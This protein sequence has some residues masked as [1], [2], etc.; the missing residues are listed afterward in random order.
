M[1]KKMETLLATADT[2]TLVTIDSRGFPHTIA[3]SPPLER[4][5]FYYFK[6]YIN[7]EGK[8]AENIRMN[9]SGSLFCFDKEKHE[10]IALKG[11]FFIE[12]LVEYK[13]LAAKLNDF[14]K[15]LNYEHPVIAIFETLSLKHYENMH[16]EILD[17]PEK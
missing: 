15:Q 2:Y 9:R 16:A 11:Y 8:T 6:F 1:D 13:L 5:G 10:S 12:E 7:G 17:V 4:N 3:V 14:Q